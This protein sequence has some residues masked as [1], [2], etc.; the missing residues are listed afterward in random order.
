MKV[1]DIFTLLGSIV[2]LAMFT[3]VLT[4]KNTVGVAKTGFNGFIGALKAAMGR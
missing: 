4:S 3:V 1:N 2:L